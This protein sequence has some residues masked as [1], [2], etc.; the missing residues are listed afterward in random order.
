MTDNM[1]IP[2][3]LATELRK[4]KVNTEIYLNNKKLKAKVKY[5]DKLEIPYILVIGDDEIKTNCIK[6]KNM[7]TGQE[8]ESK[9]EAQSIMKL[10]T[11]N[12]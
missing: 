7:I 4:L 8:Q 5:A 10:I 9:I 12:K 2:L 11:Y 6:V 3:K 1:E